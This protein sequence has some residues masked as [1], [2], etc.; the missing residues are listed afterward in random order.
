MDFNE[1]N[2][3]IWQIFIGADSYLVQR[4]GIDTRL[5]L[6][7]G[8]AFQ[9]LFMLSLAH[10]LHTCLLSQSSQKATQPPLPHDLLDHEPDYETDD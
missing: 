4:T 6:L 8:L 9:L 5:L 7:P 2:F 10:L 1:T 3:R